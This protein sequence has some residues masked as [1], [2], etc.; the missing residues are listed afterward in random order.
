VSRRAIGLPVGSRIGYHLTTLGMI[1]QNAGH[2]SLYI[3]WNH[4]EWC[5][6]ACKLFGTRDRAEQEGGI[7]AELAHPNIVRL[8]GIEDPACVLMEFLE[9]PTLR[10]MMRTR[11]HER[12]GV[13]DAIR[14]AVHV[15]AALIHMHARGILHLDVKPSNIIIS[16]GRPV[17]FDLGTARRRADWERSCLEGTD[18][19]MAPEQCLREP[20]LPAT[21]VFGLAVTLYRML[22]GKLPFPAGTRSLQHPQVTKKPTP[23]RHY[24]PSI[25]SALDHLI[26]RCLARNPDERPASPADVLPLLHDQIGSG[27]PMWPKEFR[28]DINIQAL[29]ASGGLS[30]NLGQGST[31]DPGR[32][33]PRV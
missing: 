10:E 18:P 3:V 5:P 22:T 9:G 12:L 1:D 33:A 7:I 6:M 14:A 32:Q 30:S 31:T 27:P 8:L 17:L 13:S 28:P 4:R 29:P 23:A 25:P 19:Y 2:S 21:D 20:V 24:R 15:G 11:P 16:R 26:M